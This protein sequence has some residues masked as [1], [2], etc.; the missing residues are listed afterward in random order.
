METVKIVGFATLAAVVYGILHDQVTA[1]VCV[2]YFTIAHP[3]IF[4]TDSPFLLAIG[5]GFIATWWVGLPLG[6]LLAAT[7][8]IGRNGKLGLIQLRRPITLLMAVSGCAALL[9]GFL[10]A[11]LVAMQLI[12]LP[13]DWGTVI[14]ISQWPAFA[15]AVW[16]HSASYL[17]GTLGGLVVIASTLKHRLGS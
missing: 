6:I 7:A 5:W 9:S 4:P 12:D 2:E 11:S 13:G 8:R 17:V 1:H 10:G 16:A 15:F 14:P 3:P